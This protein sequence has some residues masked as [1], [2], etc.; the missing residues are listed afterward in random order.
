VLDFGHFYPTAILCKRRTSDRASL[1]NIGKNVQVPGVALLT[2]AQYAALLE[3]LSSA[4]L[5]I[6]PV[7]G[8][9]DI[10]TAI[11]RIPRCTL[12]CRVPLRVLLCLTGTPLACT[13]SLAGAGS[14]FSLLTVH[15]KSVN[16][17]TA[18]NAAMTVSRIMIIRV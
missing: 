10:A 5:S 18:I 8:V 4:V 1:Q 14:T 7:C 2:A 12:P 16:V 15:L 6:G 17:Q 9:S 11:V 3:R 13:S